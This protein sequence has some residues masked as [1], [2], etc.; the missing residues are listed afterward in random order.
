MTITSTGCNEPLTQSLAVS[1][2]ISPHPH[3][4]QLEWKVESDRSPMETGEPGPGDKVK[5][6]SAE[7]VQGLGS[8]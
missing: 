6:C 7:T 8:L 3:H 4:E 1:P 2:Q 5:E